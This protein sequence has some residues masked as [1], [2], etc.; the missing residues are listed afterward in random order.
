M[1]GTSKA[2][3]LNPVSAATISIGAGLP[4]TGTRVFT[5]PGN[6]GSGYSDWVLVVE[7]PSFATAVAAKTSQGPLTQTVQMGETQVLANSDS[8]N[9]N[10]LLAQN[11]TLTQS[12]TIQ[13]LSFYVSSPNGSLRLGI[14]DATGPGGG[15]GTLKAQTGAF[16]PVTGW[17]T[18]NVTTQ[19]ALPAANYWLAYLPSSS[20]LKFAANFTVGSF[21]QASVAFGPMPA[22]FPA[23]SGQGATHWS[24]YGTLT[25]P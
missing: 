24:F 12:A 25:A 7:S 9:G 4:N 6:N 15:P 3:W 2:L 18:V 21:K 19:V 13:S 16:T 10:L 5:P 11:A 14:Y 17:N 23:V 1:G 20:T 22:A 8:G